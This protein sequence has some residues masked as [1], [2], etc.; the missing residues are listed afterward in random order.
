MEKL[1][2]LGPGFGEVGRRCA[3]AWRAVR[4]VL[5]AGGVTPFLNS[6][7]WKRDRLAAFNELCVPE[8]V[9]QPVCSMSH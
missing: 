5:L 3:G 6:R 4:V 9:G 8:G 7:V 2:F 1:L